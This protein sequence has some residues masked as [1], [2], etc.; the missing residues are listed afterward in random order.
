MVSMLDLCVVDL[1]FEHLLGQTKDYIKLV[2]PASP[3]KA[4]IFDE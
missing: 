1:E 3:I 4:C 2:F